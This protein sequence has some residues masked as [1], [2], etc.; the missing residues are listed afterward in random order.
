MKCQKGVPV[1][2]KAEICFTLWQKMC[3]VL[4]HWGIL[5]HPRFSW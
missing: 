4:L 3:G 1:D 5:H 2:V